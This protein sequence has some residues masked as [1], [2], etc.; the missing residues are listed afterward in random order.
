[1]GTAAQQRDFTPRGEQKP[2]RDGVARSTADFG[3][4]VSGRVVDVAW[5]QVTRVADVKFVDELLRRA[6]AGKQEPLV[7]LQFVPPTAQVPGSREREAVAELLSESARLVSHSAT[8]YAGSGFRAAMV[9]SIVI[10]INALARHP[11][12][13]RVFSTVA[14][15]AS[16]FE[17]NRHDISAESTI[18]LVERILHADVTE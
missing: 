16:W 9:R 11:Y 7:F 5:K 4:G 13:I 2:V 17:H 18:D 15:A 12:P 8:V 10:G 14:A 1:M 3:V 6:H